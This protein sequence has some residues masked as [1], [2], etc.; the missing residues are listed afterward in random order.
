MKIY[1]SLCG[2]IMLSIAIFILFASG[3]SQ[4]ANGVTIVE[5]SDTEFLILGLEINGYSRSDGIEAYLPQESSPEHVLI[6]INA[7][8]R[9]L[10]VSIEADPATGTASGFFLDEGRIFQLDM[11]QGEAVSAT[12][13]YQLQPG[14]VEAHADDI[15]VKADVLSKWFDLDI[16]LESSSLTLYIDADDAFPFE[17]AEERKN[18][19]DKLLT[20]SRRNDFDP[21]NA[22]LLP[23]GLYSKPSF[24]LQQSVVANS[25]P[26][27]NLLVG[28]S[29]VQAGFDFLYFGA[30]LNLNYL[31]DSEEQNEITNARLTFS[32]SD[33]KQEMLGKL[34]VGR[35]DIGDVDFSSVPLLA[36][37]GRGAGIRLSSEADFGFRFS[38]QL[39]NVL[40]DGDAPVDWDVELYRN[41]QFVDFQTV[42]GEA[43]FLF[44][45]VTLING[46]NRFQILLFGPEGQ[47]RSVTRDIFSGPNMLADGQTRYNFSAGLPQSDFL[48]LAEES[49]NDRTFGIGGEILHGINN[50][51]TLGANFFSGPID[52]ERSTSA[53]VSAASSFLGFNTQIQGL[54]AD[55]NR[56]A[57]QAAIRRRFLGINAALTHTRFNNFEE[58]DQDIEKSTEV[59]F[60]RNFGQLNV[61]LIGER[62]SFL[63]GEDRDIIENIVSSEILGVKFTNEL[64]KTISDNDQIDDLEGE[65]SVFDQINDIRIR[66][67]LTYDLDSDAE[68]TFRALRINA[69]K[70][71]GD[72]DAVRF[73]VGYNFPT[74]VITGD[75]R[76]S[77][78]LGPVTLDFDVGASTDQNYTAGITIRSALQPRD[79]RYQFVQPRQGTLANLGVRAFIDENG[80]GFYDYGEKP[81]E[82]M[83]FKTSRG[84]VDALTD[85]GGVAWMYGLAETP[86]RIYVSQQDIPSIYIVPLK[87]G[88]DLI[89]RRGAR[90]VVDFPF[91]QLG[92][93]DGFVFDVNTGEPLSNILV[94][95]VDANTGEE[96][97]ST[98]TEYDGFYIF[99]ALPLGS[100]KVIAS[101]GWFDEAEPD[102]ASQNIQLTTENSNILDVDLKIEAALEEEIVEASIAPVNP[103]SYDIPQE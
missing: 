86:T 77:R 10:S 90:H 56:T 35:I 3:I 36:S 60:S 37:G 23:Y 4:A 7:L 24:L 31:V 100:Y 103:N 2:C 87:K 26:D 19:A 94:K 68:D 95:V 101:D 54:Y 84:K 11:T 13:T 71:L 47:K 62:Q 6:P 92:E 44:E 88:L 79:G 20:T 97:E 69:Q 76:Y 1:K 99:S 93:I 14:D 72:Y 85:G 51:L 25:S 78:E 59:S 22:Y 58:E 42:G 57:A 53:G 5:R 17:E 28:S 45:D 81:I 15:F 18:R 75:V 55:K 65:L 39:G 73:N 16:D 41:G 83:L 33:P 27:R 49:R 46:F 70:K 12:S 102:T 40:I 38:Q 43:R 8:S 9:A 98:T 52:E 66:S 50:F 64:T 67:S 91:T 32:R 82:N 21:K 89:P 96:I 48:P 74:D 30:N 29:N 34:K 80:N 61:T 63:N